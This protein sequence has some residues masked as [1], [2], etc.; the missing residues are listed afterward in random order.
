MG[1]V[2][3]GQKSYVTFINV[4]II[5]ICSF[6]FIYT[7]LVGNLD[8]AW[9]YAFA[10]GS[11]FRAVPYNDYKT[12]LPPFFYEMMGLP[13]HINMSL[14]TYRITEVII[15]GFIMTLVYYS[16]NKKLSSGLALATTLLI[17]VFMDYNVTYNS[18][19]LLFAL[20]LYLIHSSDKEKA[21]FTH[22]FIIGIFAAMPVMF[23]Q[24]TG[25][26]MLIFELVFIFIDR[27]LPILKKI[28]AFL[29][30]VSIPC[31][32]LLIYLLVRGNFS[33][34][35]DN[36]F[37]SLFRVTSQN[38]SFEI[39]TE[40]IVTL[41]IVLA[42]LAVNIYMLVKTSDKNYLYRVFL[43]ISMVSIG[44][45]IFDPGHIFPAVV[46]GV[47]SLIYI[48]SGKI[49]KVKNYIVNLAVGLLL[50]I[51]IVPGTILALGA[52]YMTYSEF[53]YLPL[54]F[55]FEGHEGLNAKN[56]EYEDAGYKVVIVSEA[57]ADF[58]VL[59][60]KFEPPYHFSG[61]TEPVSY[62]KGLPDDCIVVIS[63]TYKEDNW[64]NPPEIYDYVM[65]NYTE[66]DRFGNFGY[67]TKVK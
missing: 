11:V 42:S 22:Y 60:G 64:Q 14:I 28:L 51:L 40:L 30:G 36:C 47:I 52:E 44:V 48:Y 8:E 6:F 29:C 18:M 27:N 57:K 2:V 24:T 13:L 49:P 15:N 7:R 3:N 56:R 41:I 39:S 38:S 10:R 31:F 54:A 59:E 50:L 61:M 35:W 21:S 65:D 43:I 23:R 45:P 9:N 66:I 62:V 37:F 1:K 26:L 4:G 32:T 46:I 58:D 17:Q 5:F 25:G 33:G 12:V 34:Y 55:S 20:V 19:L 53:S 67:Y 16:L 63:D